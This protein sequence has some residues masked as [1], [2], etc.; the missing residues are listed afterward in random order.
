MSTEPNINQIFRQCVPYAVHRL[1]F[2]LQFKN[3]LAAGDGNFGNEML[4]ARNGKGEL[5]LRGTS[6]AGVLRNSYEKQYGEE[7]T[8]LFFGTSA[9]K[10]IEDDELSKSPLIVS[11]VVLDCG[12]NKN[13]N[14]TKEYRRTHHLRNR[15]TGS[16]LDNGLYSIEIAPPKTTAQVT[17]WFNETEQ[18]KELGKDFLENL[19]ALIQNCLIFGGN[20]NRG[21]GLAT[22][23]E[24]VHKCYELQK[25]SEYAEYL[26]DHFAWR[27]DKTLNN[28][29]P[30]QPANNVATQ[31]LCVQFTLQIP[32]GQ[33]LLIAE[34]ND[35][36]PHKI[37]AADGN[38]YYLLPGSTLHGLFRNWITRLAARE[39]KF[40]SDS[41]D[42]YE[43]KQRNIT[44]AELGWMFNEKLDVK[45][46]GIK[47]FDKSYPVES[48]FGSLHKAGRLH[49]SDALC[50]VN[51]AVT[52]HR[53]HVALDAVSGGAIDSLLFDNDV[54]IKGSFDVTMI[55]RDVKDYEAKWLAKTL[56]ALHIGLLRVG[57]SKAAGRLELAGNLQAA[58]NFADYFDTITL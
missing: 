21:V 30:L 1:T 16:V 26:N 18:L 20:S 53:K 52:Q 24:F 3:G 35:M 29:E 34:G 14:E 5:V 9:G 45:K 57:S 58:G 4:F 32:R 6:I 31:N 48:L 51:Q 27:N 55:V 28:G 36:L 37:R 2:T 17:L 38:E 19:A 25:K 22:A 33:D 39:G 12:Q 8:E 10:N 49:F 47:K 42:N 23:N 46:I 54:L 41:V 56:K 40:V 7:N 11:D 44:G 15:H 43:E 13:D 50:P